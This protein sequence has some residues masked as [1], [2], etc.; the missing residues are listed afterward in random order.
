MTADKGPTV[1]QLR[2]CVWLLSVCVCVCVC[3]CV[4]ACVRA[5]VCV[6]VCARARSGGRAYMSAGV[7]GCVGVYMLVFGYLHCFSETVTSLNFYI[8]LFQI[9]TC[10]N[11]MSCLFVNPLYE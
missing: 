7:R 8:Y 6:Y 11:A 4:R 5:C 3:V 1:V 9:Y 2:K 10:R